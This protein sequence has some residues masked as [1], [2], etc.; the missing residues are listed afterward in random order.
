MVNSKSQWAVSSGQWSVVSGQSTVGSG[1]FGAAMVEV[2]ASRDSIRRRTRHAEN[3]PLTFDCDRP[4]PTV[5]CPL[6]TASLTTAHCSPPTAYI[7]LSFSADFSAGG[8]KPPSN[9]WRMNLIRSSTCCD[10]SLDLN[11]G[12]P[13]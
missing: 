7:F 8:V 2:T 5:H 6:L 9:S 13:S 11:D 10:E 4:L 12:I 3:K 1:Q